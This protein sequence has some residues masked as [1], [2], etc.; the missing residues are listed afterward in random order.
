MADPSEESGA[1]NHFEPDSYPIEVRR[2]I[3]DYDELQDAVAEAASAAAA[4]RILD[5][6]TGTGETAKRVLARQ[7]EASIV[8][9]DSSREMLEAARGLL[10][11]GRIEQ[12]LLQRL[13][14]PLPPGPFDLVVSALAVH[15]LESGDKQALFRR[16]GEVL[17]PRGLFVLADVIVPD[18]SE[19]A[20]IPIDSP[21]DRPD[22][23]D[24][25]LAW[26]GEAGLKA[27]VAWSKN[28]LAVI[29]AEQPTR[30]GSDA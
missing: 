19:L 25:Q 5:L 20:T 21:F 7:P 28:D 23:L 22:R 18:I 4:R 12:V 3:P 9:L 26:I 6:G 29:V 14:D 2:E 17:A 30:G 13:E 16:V 27:I 24:D 8:L 15:H 10:P 11:E 1:Q